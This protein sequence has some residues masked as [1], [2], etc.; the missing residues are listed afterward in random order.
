MQCLWTDLVSSTPVWLIPTDKVG[1]VSGD[2]GHGSSHIDAYDELFKTPSIADVDPLDNDQEET[3]NKVIFCCVVPRV[4]T[5]D[6]IQQHFGLF[7]CS[8]V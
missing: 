5:N 8:S 1:S 3:G 4:N 7:W 2:S 6:G